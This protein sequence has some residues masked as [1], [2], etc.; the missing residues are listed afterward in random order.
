LSHS[1]RSARVRGRRRPAAPHADTGHHRL[2]D[3]RIM[4][5]PGGDDPRDRPGTVVGSQVTLR[6]ESGDPAGFFGS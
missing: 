6:C 3:H 1:T 5:L 4:V 2:E